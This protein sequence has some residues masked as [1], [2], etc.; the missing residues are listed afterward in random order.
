[1]RTATHPASPG[2]ARPALCLE[3]DTGDEQARLDDCAQAPRRLRDPRERRRGFELR[4]LRLE[5]LRQRQGG[6]AFPP[7]DGADG[8]GAPVVDAEAE[9]AC[10][11]P[12]AER[13]VGRAE[14]EIP[15]E[16]RLHRAGAQPL[17][18]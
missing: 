2:A 10:D 14:V 7:A 17:L 4:N 3:L 12:P 15:T 8:E 18:E 6:A 16:E 1:M 11:A 5:R 9:P 13:P